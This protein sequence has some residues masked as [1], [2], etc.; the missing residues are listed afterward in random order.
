LIAALCNSSDHSVPFAAVGQCSRNT[1]HMMFCALLSML[2]QRS[3][4]GRTVLHKSECR[5][6]PHFNA[7]FLSTV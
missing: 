7:L 1:C 2:L 5:F 3:S 4:R 6:L